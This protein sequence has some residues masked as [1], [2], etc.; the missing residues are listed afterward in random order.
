M[1]LIV[2]GLGFCTYSQLSDDYAVAFYNFYCLIFISHFV[3]EEINAQVL[4]SCNAVCCV[5]LYVTL[6]DFLSYRTENE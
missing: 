4:A 2:F 5:Q 6:I 3:V 1:C